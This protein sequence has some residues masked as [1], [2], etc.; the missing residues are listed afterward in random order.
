MRNLLRIGALLLGMS[1]CGASDAAPTSQFQIEGHVLDDLTGHALEHATVDFSSDTLDRAEASTDHEGHF[2][3]VVDV[4]DGVDFGIV[5]ATHAD[6]Q[7]SAEQTLYFDG[8]EHQLTLRLR[9]T[10][11]TK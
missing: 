4:R 7:P 8:T 10:V 1:G 5:S 11:P 6:Y 2:S 3:L 9:A